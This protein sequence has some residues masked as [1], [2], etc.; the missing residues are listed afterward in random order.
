MIARLARRRAA[1]TALAAPR[2]PPRRQ[3]ALARAEYRIDRERFADQIALGK[4]APKLAQAR[5]LVRRF[6]AL[7]NHVATQ[8]AGHRDNG[9]DDGQATRIIE[10]AHEGLVEL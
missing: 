2:F 1:R 4:L 6:D 10:L 3:R 8:G 7:G 5:E 9:A